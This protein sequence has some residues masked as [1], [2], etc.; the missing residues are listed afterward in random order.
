MDTSPSRHIPLTGTFNIRD[1]GG[2]STA[3]GSST[4]WR[5]LLRADSLHK[6]DQAGI[7]A[8]L[9]EGLTTV[10]DLRHEH[11]LIAAPSPFAAHAGVTYLNVDLLA[12]LLPDAHGEYQEGR[13]VLLDLYV[14]V[15]DDRG[16]KL[17]QILDAIANA[18]DG[19]V[20]FHCAAGK[21]RTGI[22]AALLLGIAE[23]QRDA[24]LDDYELTTLQMAA[25]MP[26]YER[27]AAERGQD[28][29]NLHALLASRRE[30]MAALLDHI[31][32][33][34]GGIPA[35]LAAIALSPNATDKLRSRLLEREAL[36]G[37]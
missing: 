26:D 28:L 2:Y 34:H 9:A 13:D 1:L 3:T 4:L 6:L 23:V 31:D 17:L 32:M 20:L 10:V 25:V 8:L 35:Y 33:R 21:D 22:V 37:E 36:R 18:P 16:A 11:E 12:D 5:R 30:T 7:A 27:R 29:R 14:R 24:I 15:I 19:A